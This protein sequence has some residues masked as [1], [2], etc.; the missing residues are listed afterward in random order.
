MP[1]STETEPAASLAALAEHA[2]RC[3]E[4][5]DRAEGARDVT[6]EIARRRVRVR[7][8]DA[9]TLAALLPALRHHPRARCDAGAP[10]LEIRAWHGDAPGT[11]PQAPPDLQARW[12]RGD[13][14]ASTAHVAHPHG[15]ACIVTVYDRAGKFL[16]VVAGPEAFDQDVPYLDLAVD[17]KGRVLVL[18]PAQKKVRIFVRKGQP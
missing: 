14:A 8:A 17:G 2:A 11:V 15:E 9:A 10:D 4:Q 18:D 1:T 16:C 12:T 13:F 7:C 3:F 6:L 5:A